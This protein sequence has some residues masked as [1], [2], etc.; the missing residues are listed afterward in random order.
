MKSKWSCTWQRLGWIGRGSCFQSPSQTFP[1]RHPPPWFKN[2]ITYSKA[3]IAKHNLLK[4]YSSETKGQL[5]RLFSL[6]FITKKQLH[7]TQK[8]FFSLWWS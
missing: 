2:I 4:K 7:L 3:S 1:L 8:F 5:A 6:G